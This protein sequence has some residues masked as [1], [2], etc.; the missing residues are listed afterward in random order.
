M[1]QRLIADNECVYCGSDNCDCSQRIEEDDSQI[2]AR[3]AAD[4]QQ[5]AA[6]I[7]PQSSIELPGLDEELT[8]EIGIND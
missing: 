5:E 3:E 4:F 2:A 6:F 8:C 7:S 1:P